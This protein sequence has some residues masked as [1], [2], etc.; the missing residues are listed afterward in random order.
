MYLEGGLPDPA[1]ELYERS[2][3]YAIEHNI[4][5]EN[6]AYSKLAQVYLQKGDIKAAEETLK[7]SGYPNNLVMAQ[8]YAARGRDDSAYAGFKKELEHSVTPDQRLNKAQA[9][10]GLSALY[11]SDGERDLALDHGL[12]AYKLADSLGNRKFKQQAAR[13]LS[14][15]YGQAGDNKKS[16][17][18]LRI[19][20]ALRDSIAGMDFQNV[21]AYYENKSAIEKE[22]ARVKVLSAEKSLQE[23]K[24]EEQRKSKNLILLMS[25]IALSAAMVVIINVQ[26]Q[27]KKIQ[28]QNFVIDEQR[29][30]VELALSEL[31][32]TQAQLIQREKLASL[33]EL[34]AGIAH[35]IQNPLNFVNNFSEV[36]S[37]L[38]SEM[39]VEIGSGNLQSAGQLAKSIVENQEKI[40][41][42][43]KRADA[44]VKSM[45]QHSQGGLGKKEPTDINALA[46]EYLRLAYHG[47]RAKDNS[48][49][50]DY[51]TAFDSSIGKVKVVPQEIGRVL[52]NLINNAFF[53]VSE[54]QKAQ[55]NGYKPE[56]RV[57]T[58]RLRD[59]IE[60]RVS[61]NGMG[62]PSKLLDKIF[63]PFF[64]TKP[65]GQGTGLGL[66][67]SYDIVTKGHGGTINVE[68]KE[69][70]GTSFLVEIPIEAA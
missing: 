61:D 29:R 62:I 55:G 54:R 59:R 58:K 36:N 44:I 3:A 12:K 8:I 7:K 25:L 39:N 52:L 37:E 23:Q 27:K 49:N 63:Q 15:I 65:A 30:E 17:E 1:A 24:T 31:K 20:D 32:S 2:I 35:E 43:G 5:P 53:A 60:I 22:Q 13:L 14:M 28:G 67:L 18:F 40:V 48:F 11:F 64:T 4:K 26:R 41:H 38:I 33:G 16:L 9:L 70:E 47:L 57:S 66:S 34:T 50:V 51:K 46:E 69:G 10:Q 6:L 21:L 42:H 56:V 45:L 19:A 68:T